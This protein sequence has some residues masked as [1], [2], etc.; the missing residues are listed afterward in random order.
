[1]RSE[2]SSIVFAA[3]SPFIFSAISAAFAG[4]PCGTSAG[5]PVLRADAEDELNTLAIAA[6]EVS[7]LREVGVATNEYLP[8][9]TFTTDADGAIDLDRR[10]LRATAD[11][12]SG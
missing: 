6:I 5:R 2:A 12:R 11:C 9:T 7:R 4:G 10:P 1:M 8:E 3:L